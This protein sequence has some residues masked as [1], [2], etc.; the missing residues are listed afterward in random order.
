MNIMKAVCRVRSHL[1][2]YSNIQNLF[3]MSDE[4]LNEFFDS[5]GIIE[6]FLSSRMN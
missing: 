3:Y 4:L 6:I 5:K 2:N 1:I